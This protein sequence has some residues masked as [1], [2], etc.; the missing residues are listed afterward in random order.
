MYLPKGI[1]VTANQFMEPGDT[2]TFQMEYHEGKAN[3]VTFLSKNKKY[4]TA[5]KTI[6]ASSEK[7]S[8]NYILYGPITTL[9]QKF[10]LCFL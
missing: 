10:L 6:T 7:V 8:N 5:G 9:H 1:D 4:W 2:E 3:Q